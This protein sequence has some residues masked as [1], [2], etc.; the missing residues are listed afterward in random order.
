MT[1]FEVAPPVKE[2]ALD[3]EAARR[4]VK[5]FFVQPP[6]NLDPYIDAALMARV[7]AR[8]QTRLSSAATDLR[9]DLHRITVPTLIVQG[10]RDTSRPPSLGK[11]MADALPDA[12]LHVIPGV[13]HTPMLEDPQ[14]WQT[15]FHAFL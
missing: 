5:H 10:E 4:L 7:E 14:T 9:P 1:Y 15:L 8:T 2:I 11:V 12:E 3:R 6:A 13:G